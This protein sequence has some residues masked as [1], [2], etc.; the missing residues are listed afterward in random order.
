MW[1]RQNQRGYVIDINDAGLFS[2]SEATEIVNQDNI[3]NDDVMLR[4][5]DNNHM[6]ENDDQE[7]ESYDYNHMIER[8]K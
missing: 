4:S 5:Y 2:L 3:K 6:T 8:T 7:N 1:W